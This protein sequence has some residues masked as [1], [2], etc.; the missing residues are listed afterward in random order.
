MKKKRYGAI[1]G[2]WSFVSTIPRALHYMNNDM[3][4][5]KGTQEYFEAFLA[6]MVAM[7]SSTFLLRP[8]RKVEYS[9]VA[10]LK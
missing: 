2:Q 8:K 7:N 10:G 9:L 3:T 5:S 4:G 1:S 6:E